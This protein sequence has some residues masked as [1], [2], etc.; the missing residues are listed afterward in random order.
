METIGFIGIGRMGKPMA[1][2]LIDRGWPLIVHD[3]RREAAAPLLDRGA[4]WAA[5][6]AAV[7]SEAGVV[8]TIV[9]SS[10]EVQDVFAGRGGLLETFGPRHLAIEMT[11]A[12]PSATRAIAAAVAARG[13][14][15][16]DAPVSGGV[17]GAEAGTLAI[18]VGGEAVLLARARPILEAM[19]ERIFHVG[20]VGAG[21]AIK[22]VN[23]ACS[24]AALLMTAEAV[25]VAAK[26]GVDPARA[27]EVIQ[28]S[29]GRSN[30]TETKFPRF[31]LN[32]RF[33][34]GFAIRLM[35]KDLDGYMR[36]AR[37][38]GVPSLLG[39]PASELYRMA[40]ARDMGDL[41]HTAAVRLIE[42]WAGI[43]L[44]AS[45]GGTA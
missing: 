18:M 41:D 45:G 19:G 20:P 16:V 37:E 25:A 5:S 4:R 7:A 22:L 27:V 1:S 13:A 9:P 3:V 29:S 21:H 43:E 15:L 28:A 10:R 17:R 33:D 8:I 11:S 40:L 31:I 34:A 42:E 36:L 35:S 44:R 32:G 12:D 30:A 2:R 6:P 23:N 39:G 24:A 14:A 38:S 26:A